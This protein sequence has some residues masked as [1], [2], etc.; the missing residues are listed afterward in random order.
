MF[1]CC[2]N[3]KG[4][5]CNYWYYYNDSIRDWLFWLLSFPVCGP[6]LVFVAQAHCFPLVRM[7]RHVGAYID[8][9]LSTSKKNPGISIVLIILRGMNLSTQYPVI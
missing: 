3:G 2:G 5:K 7:F 9:A 8:D 1:I 4:K 6:C